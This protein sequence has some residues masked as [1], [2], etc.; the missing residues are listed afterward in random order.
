MSYEFS[1]TLPSTLCIMWPVYLQSLKLL[2]LMA[3]GRCIYKKIHFLT[4]DLGVKVT[5][6]IAQCPLHHVAYTVAMSVR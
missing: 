6:N 4:F 3:M 1:E 5:W 2:R